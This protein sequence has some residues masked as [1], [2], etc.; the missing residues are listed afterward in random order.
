MDNYNEI[1]FDNITIN[2]SYSIKP[3]G[4]IYMLS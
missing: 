3:G 1:I 2:M 4:L